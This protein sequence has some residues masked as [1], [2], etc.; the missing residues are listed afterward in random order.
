MKRIIIVI[1][2]V[3]VFLIGLSVLLY[4]FVSDYFNAMGQSR[5]MNDYST[6]LAELSEIDYSELLGAAQEYNEK[7]TTNSRRF[8]LR[9]EDAEEYNKMLNFTGTGV[10]GT[11]EIN[12]IKVKLPIYLGTDE[13]ILQVGIGH[14]EGSSL[15]IGGPSTHCVI[16]GHRGLPS[17][18]LLTH[19]DELVIGDRFVLKILNEKLTYEIDDINIV[20]PENTDKLGIYS[21]EDYCTLVTCTPLGVNSH[22]LLL[23]GKRV[24]FQDG[25]IDNDDGEPYQ[26]PQAGKYTVRADAK[27]A[28]VIVGY[29]LT[30]VPILLIV[31]I[32]NFVKSRKPKK[33][34]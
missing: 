7:L 22:R 8:A 23:R 9:P 27:R 11:L 30:A 18:T 3:L 26:T 29:V 25:E 1:V 10:I 28:N 33:R 14:L 13:G 4:P 5:V 24:I 12:A 21:N 32:Y 2:F 31:F 6:K 17:S 20:E 19:A 34:R 15:P 16:T